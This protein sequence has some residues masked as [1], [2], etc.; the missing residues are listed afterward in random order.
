MRLKH[1]AIAT[2]G[3]KNTHFTF[4]HVFVP[5]CMSIT[6]SSSFLVCFTLILRNRL[7]L[8]ISVHFYS[9]YEGHKHSNDVS[10]LHFAFQIRNTRA[11][12]YEFNAVD[13]VS[14]HWHNGLICLDG[15][16]LIAAGGC[17][18][19]KEAAGCLSAT[20]MPPAWPP[21]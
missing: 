10:L 20:Y 21:L 11:L 9:L 17:K 12:T 14:V 19:T 1:F 4:K 5:F 6:I 2:S 7:F 16:D 13:T 3:A 8:N 15:S 18:G